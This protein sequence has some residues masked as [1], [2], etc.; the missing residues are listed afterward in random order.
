MP[1]VKQLKQEDSTPKARKQDKIVIIDDIVEAVRTT[2]D[3]YIGS[4]GNTGFISMIRE[5]LQNSLDEISKGNSI[6]KRVIVSYDARDHT[7][8]IEDFGQGIPIDILDKVFT[9]LHSS[10]NYH[11]T[12]GSGNFSSGKNGATVRSTLLSQ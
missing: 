5:V 12:A 4:L 10:S 2:P 1:K 11:K 8:I 9:T 7:V 6:D 3:V